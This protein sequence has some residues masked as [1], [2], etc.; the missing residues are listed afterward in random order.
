MEDAGSGDRDEL[1][2]ATEELH[3]KSILREIKKIIEEN[4]RGAIKNAL[5]H[6]RR[7][8]S[9]MKL[10]KQAVESFLQSQENRPKTVME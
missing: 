5:T 7:R 3:G 8:L 9:E 2:Q 6:A 10:E 1:Y 4:D